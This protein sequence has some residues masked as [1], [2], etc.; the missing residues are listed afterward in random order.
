VTSALTAAR[1]PRAAAL[2]FALLCGIPAA[3]VPVRAAPKASAEE[4]AGLALLDS[5][6]AAQKTLTDLS[7]LFTE[8]AFQ[9]VF[10]ESLTSRGQVFFKKPG[11][12]LLRYAAPDSSHLVVNG[13][14]VWLYHVG[15]RQ[16]H[17]FALDEESVAYGLLFGFGGSFTDAKK[18]FRFVADK[19]TTRR[20][21]R[22]LRA[23]PLTGSA[24]AED[25]EEIV[26]A[27]DPKRWLPVRTR[28]RETTGDE[29]IFAFEHVTRNPGLSEDLF[30]FK[31]PEGVEVFDMES[32]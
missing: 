6:E 13:K 9:S 11:K 16:A 21:E 23:V 20:G 27:I 10:E 7:A 25:I 1:A 4:R 14:V 30:L 29:R 12:L 28:F 2:L 19:A 24:A 22:V 15:N 5:I 17:R 8:T 31:P 3:A 18:S 26:I 32:K